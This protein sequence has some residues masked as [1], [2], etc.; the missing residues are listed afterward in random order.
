MVAKSYHI[1]HSLDLN[2]EHKNDK[3]L[4][5]LAKEV[6]KDAHTYEL[7]Q[8]VQVLQSKKCLLEF[9]QHKLREILFQDG[10]MLNFAITTC[11]V[12][13]KHAV[14]SSSLVNKQDDLPNNLPALS[15]AFCFLFKAL[16]DGN[17]KEWIKHY[18]RQKNRI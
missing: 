12:M 9:Q 6:N 2:D 15:F 11:M 16:M 7:H 4:Q 5:K 1:H 10:F 17:I 14:L 8:T 13:L 3:I 18:T